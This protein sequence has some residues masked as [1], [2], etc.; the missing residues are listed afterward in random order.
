MELKT[1]AGRLSADDD[2]TPNLEN[3]T[4]ERKDLQDAKG[5][6]A[7]PRSL[8]FWFQSVKIF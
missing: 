8:A 3:T 4:E 2:S 6:N 1:N 7:T 5:N